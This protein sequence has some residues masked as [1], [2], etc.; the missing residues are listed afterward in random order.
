MARIVGLIGALT[1]LTGL[2][3]APA[4]AEEALPPVQ[5]LCHPAFDADPCDI[6]LDTTDQR[7]GAVTAPLVPPESEKPVDCFYVYPTVSDQLGLYADPP[8]QPEVDSIASMQAARFAGQC[9]VFT[10]L[11]RQLTLYPGISLQ[12]LGLPLLQQSYRDVLDAWQQYL[13]H[14]N[15]G[16]GVIFIGHSQGTLLLRKLIREAIDPDPDLRQRLVGAFLLGGNVETLRGSTV[17]GDFANIPVCTQ[18]GESGCAVAYSTTQVDP[19]LALSIFGNSTADILSASAGAPSGPQFEVACTDPAIL[20]GAPEPV[21]LTVPTA[22]YASGYLALLLDYM[23][24][25]HTLPKSASTWTT[26]AQRM[27][28]EC[29]ERHGYHVYQYR[30]LDPSAPQIN[31]LPY[32]TSH[33]LDINLGYDRLVAIAAQQIASWKSSR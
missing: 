7:T 32:A 24:F 27:Q 26:S 17:G 13:V 4:A 22:P 21:G 31:E 10:P 1:L 18:Q 8:R 30:T 29:Q 33:L 23:T 14:E 3:V 9:R 12:L 25:P 16:R 20:S 11:Y 15:N 19:L 28:G 2:W 5:W 6:P